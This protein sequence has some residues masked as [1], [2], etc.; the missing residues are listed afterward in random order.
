MISLREITVNNFS[1][2]IALQVADSQ[3]HLVLSNAISIAQSKV[4]PECIPLAIYKDDMPV[5]FLMYCKD[6]DDDEYWLYRLMIDTHHQGHGYAKQAMEI[7][8]SKIKED[9]TK[10]KILLGVH[11]DGGASVRVYQS[12][13]FVFTGQVFGQEHIM[14]LDY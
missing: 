9:K 13:G 4:M 14:Q 3:T 1:D 2:V 6:R 11:R 12:L 10:H 8:V 5:G 7:L